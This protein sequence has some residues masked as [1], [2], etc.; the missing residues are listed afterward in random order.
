MKID[1]KLTAIIGIILVSLSVIIFL[2][3]SM[4]K[5]EKNNY[6]TADPEPWIEENLITETAKDIAINVKKATRDESEIIK[7]KQE[8][9]TEN[10]LVTFFSHGYYNGTAFDTSYVTADF[11]DH[12][13]AYLSE[14]EIKDLIKRYAKIIISKEMDASD[15]IINAI[16]LAKLNKTT[17]S[18]DI[19]IF[20]DEDWKNQLNYT[21]IVWADDFSDRSKIKQR[22]FDFAT[23]KDGIYIDIIKGTSWK[24]QNPIIGG[25]LVGE[26][27]KDTVSQS[28]FNTTFI[29]VR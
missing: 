2:V 6:F 28:K 21:N 11:Y 17:E 22:P 14:N 8:Y 13:T 10:G 24:K 12:N 20:V 25:L 16:I 19:Y 3:L 5:P 1:T 9:Y 7:N 23:S 18:Y 29:Y 15:G 4:P 26:V 27:S